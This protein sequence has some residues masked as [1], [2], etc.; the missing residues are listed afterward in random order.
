MTATTT[1]GAKKIKYQQKQ[2]TVIYFLKH[3]RF[4]TIMRYINSLRGVLT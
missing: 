4:S 3:Y 2:S 1:F